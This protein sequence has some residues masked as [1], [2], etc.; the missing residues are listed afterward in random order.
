MFVSG[1]L[2][3]TAAEA[4]WDFSSGQWLDLSHSYGADTIY[5]PTSEKFSRETV[6]EGETEKGYYY[7]AYS[8]ATAEHGGTHIDAPIHFFEGRNTVDEI[9]LERL[10][11][12]VVVVDV[13]DSSTAN[14]DYQV[15]VA[16]IRDWESQFG[17]IPNGAIVL[18]NTGFAMHWPDSEAYLGTN[19]RGEGAVTKLHFPGIHPD[20]ARWLVNERELAA[21]GLDT[22]SIDFGQSTHYMSHRILFE[23]DIPGFENL[24]NLDGLPPTGALLVALP[25]KIEG[26]SGGPLRVVAFVPE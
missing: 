26:G 10:I 17:Q 6:F 11:A 18:F 21:V 3:L 23:H 15:S 8:V 1:C 2:F 19:E 22:A 25:M 14:P 20:T 4:D 7:S 12:P 9:P 13:S 24:A 16:D 5:W